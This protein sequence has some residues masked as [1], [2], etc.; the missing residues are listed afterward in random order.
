MR[1]RSSPPLRRDSRAS[2]GDTYVCVR[3]Y[4]YNSFLPLAPHVAAPLLLALHT[5]ALLNSSRGC[6][7]RSMITVTR[8]WP[9]K[10]VRGM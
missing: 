9:L 10:V 1:R 8:H 4:E 3:P 2:V 5:V 7:Q 6:P